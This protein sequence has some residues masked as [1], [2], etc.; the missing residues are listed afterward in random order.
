MFIE[1]SV[2]P[3]LGANHFEMRFDAEMLQGLVES[4]PQYGLTIHKFEAAP[5]YVLNHDLVNKL[6]KKPEEA[7]YDLSI[8]VGFI[9]GVGLSDSLS[10]RSQRD[11][12]RRTQLTSAYQDLYERANIIRRNRIAEVLNRIE[13]LIPLYISEDIGFCVTMADQV[14]ELILELKGINDSEENYEKKD[15]EGKIDYVNRIRMLA[16]QIIDKFCIRTEET[17]QEQLI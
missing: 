17:K 14:D 13:L 3:G 11:Y 8:L 5:T 2:Q 1:S 7:I 12:W 4:Y 9:Q 16:L 10:N 15:L 6:S